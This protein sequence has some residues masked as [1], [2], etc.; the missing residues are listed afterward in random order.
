MSI[1]LILSFLAFSIYK[2][3]TNR[4][5]SFMFFIFCIFS[6]FRLIPPELI[7]GKLNDF[8]LIYMFV[9]IALSLFTKGT[10]FFSVKND[11]VG[12]IILILLSYWTL[13][14]IGT[15]AFTNEN[16]MLAFQAFRF[17]LLFLVYF[18]VRDLSYNDKAKVLKYLFYV[19]ILSATLYVIQP[20]GIHLYQGGVDEVKYAG[21]QNRY[22]NTPL[23]IHFF[24]ILLFVSNFLKGSKLR[25]IYLGILLCAL[26]LPM[27]RTPM[28]MTCV[29]LLL[30]MI[31][32]RKYSKL[33]KFSIIGGIAIAL[34]WPFLS[35][36]FQSTNTKSDI[37]SA[38]NLQN[39]SSFD[40]SEGGTFSFRIAMLM[41]RVEY[42]VNSN[43]I[44]L[45]VGFPHEMSKYTHSHFL[46]KIGTYYETKDGPSTSYIETPDI[47]WSTILMRSGL[48]GLF[49]ILLLIA[50]ILL[51]LYKSN[52]IIALPAFLWIIYLCLVSFS[53][54]S[55]GFSAYPN[56]LLIFIL[57]FISYDCQQ[58]RSQGRSEA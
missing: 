42:L 2:W 55:I 31:L 7:P 13:L 47:T 15:I 17:R 33:V 23:T 12:K 51:S 32:K 14:F 10:K 3:K 6:G 43:N 37:E 19:I 22:R 49:L 11:K 53:G 24:I 52:S 26:I 28:I 54:D 58:M 30:Y 56:Y 25:V 57:Y 45:G 46:F 27:S 39:S 16:S 41:E 38:L 1:V 5:L 36:R 34:C 50:K 20:L 29:V 18:I 9:I 8:A 21:E 4:A 35:Y 40:D 48:V 44:L